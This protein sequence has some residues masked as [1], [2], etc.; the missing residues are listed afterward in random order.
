MPYSDHAAENARK[1]E[2]DIHNIKLKG[3][4]DPDDDKEVYLINDNKSDA[5]G[6]LYSNSVIV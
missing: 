3:F 5:A 6:N 1:A 4:Y 2:I